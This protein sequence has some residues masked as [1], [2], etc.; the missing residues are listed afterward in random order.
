M[1]YLL[2]HF[3]KIY[4]AILLKICSWLMWMATVFGI[5]RVVPSAAVRSVITKVVDPNEVGRI[6]AI[7]GATE[8]LLPL[9]MAPLGTSIFNLSLQQ[10]RDCGSVLYG[11]T[12]SFIFASF[13]ALYTD[14]IWW[15]NAHLM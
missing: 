12:C 1:Y 6:F 14:T 4:N 8:A 9:F 7:Y 5:L 15:S 10:N 2:C 3:I 11:T 13:I